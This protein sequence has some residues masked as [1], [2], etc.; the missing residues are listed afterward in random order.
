MAPVSVVYWQPTGGLMA[1]ADR[2]GQKVGSHL[3]L[4]CIHRINRV[5]SRKALS[6]M[7]T[8]WTLSRYYCY[9]III[10][11]L[12][13]ECRQHLSAETKRSKNLT[14]SKEMNTNW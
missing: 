2:L 5:N 7:I 8:P 14:L 9:I 4:F 12:P 6:T 13:A 1:L 3:K 10:K 11:Q